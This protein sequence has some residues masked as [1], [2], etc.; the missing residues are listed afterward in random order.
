M[1]KQYSLEM[2]KAIAK[3]VGCHP[4]VGN[5]VEPVAYCYYYSHQVSSSVLTILGKGFHN[6]SV[7]EEL[8]PQFVRCYLK[9]TVCQTLC[10]LS[11]KVDSELIIFRL[12]FVVCV[13]SL[14]ERWCWS[15]NQGSL[16]YIFTNSATGTAQTPQPAVPER[17]LAGR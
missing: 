10:I 13:K 11:H 5:E 7:E 15:L 3:S 2:A 12:I 6:Y 9:L 16:T 14:I 1:K 8:A 4:G 17:L